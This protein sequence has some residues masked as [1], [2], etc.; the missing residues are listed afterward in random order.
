MKINFLAFQPD[1]LYFIIIQLFP[2]SA[3]LRESRDWKIQAGRDF[4]KE[5]L[6]SG[7][8]RERIQ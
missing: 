7:V 4:I 1:F 8:C 3:E 6:Y 2:I 5:T